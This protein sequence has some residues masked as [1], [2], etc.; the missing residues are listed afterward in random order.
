MTNGEHAEEPTALLERMTL[1]EK[2]LM[3][4][5]KNVWETPEID[6]L[7]IPSLKVYIYYSSHHQLTY[8]VFLTMN[9]YAL[10]RSPTV[11]TEHEEET[12]STAQQQHAFLPVYLLPQLLTGIFPA[13]SAKPWVKKP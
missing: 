4:A 12:S 7:G 9:T 2:I 1:D 13:R 11:P 3:L 10:L 6:R 8:H 5:A